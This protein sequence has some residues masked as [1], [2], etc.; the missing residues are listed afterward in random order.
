MKRKF[1]L[2]WIRNMQSRNNHKLAMV[3]IT[4]SILNFFKVTLDKMDILVDES[5]NLPRKLGFAPKNEEIYKSDGDRKAA[6]SV[7][8]L[9]KQVFT[10]IGNLNTKRKFNLFFIF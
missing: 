4:S 8:Y 6:R 10:Q 1:K 7:N 2:Y 3:K 5:A 9:E